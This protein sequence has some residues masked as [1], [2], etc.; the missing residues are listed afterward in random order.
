MQSDHK[1]IYKLTS[2]RTGK[3]EEMYK[4]LG[5]FVFAN[6][7]SFFRRPSSLIVKLKGV[8]S[9]YLR[10]K[11]MEILVGYYPPDFSRKKEDFP[12]EQSILKWENKVEIYNLFT[13]RLKDYEKY[14]ELRNQIRQ[15]RNETQ[16][17]LRPLNGE[18]QS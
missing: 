3:S 15:K 16:V 2:I 14:T 10:R 13:E 7:Y 12:S 18:D 1:E 4:E 6:L 11:R 17:L 9:W 5:N 8:G